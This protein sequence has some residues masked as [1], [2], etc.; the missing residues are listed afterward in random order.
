MAPV[1]QRERSNPI[2]NMAPSIQSLVESFPHPH[3]P[4][5]E[6]PCR[7][8]CLPAIGKTWATFKIDFAEAYQDFRLSQATTQTKGFHGANNTID[9]LVTDTAVAFANLATVTASDRKL[10]ADLAA[11]NPTLLAQLS[12]KDTDISKLQAQLATRNTRS[13]SSRDGSSRP[14]PRRY[15]NTNYCWTHGWDVHESHTSSTCNHQANGHKT[16]ATR[17]STTGGTDSNKNKAAWQTG[18]DTNPVAT[19]SLSY[20]NN[21]NSQW[22]V[23]L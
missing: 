17:S 14:R 7:G 16:S 21:N 20:S 23:W 9:W 6:G 19:H 13:S 2:T 10:M 3:I 11:S 1:Q 15:H 4:A 22:L 12:S 18:M 8:Q 5:F